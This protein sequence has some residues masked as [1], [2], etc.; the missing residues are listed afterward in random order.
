MPDARFILIIM[1]FFAINWTF[2]HML[3]SG[4]Q[5]VALLNRKK[6]KNNA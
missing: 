3:V 1:A 2:V 4:G 5:E 6:G